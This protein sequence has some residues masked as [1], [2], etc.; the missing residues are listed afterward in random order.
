MN[1]SS[2]QHGSSSLSNV[3]SDYRSDRIK[4]TYFCNILLKILNKN[5]SN[6]TFTVIFCLKDNGSGKFFQ[7]SRH[8]PKMGEKVAQVRVSQHFT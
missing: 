8:T 1:V 5:N 7:G 4:V 3:P 2:D 6:R